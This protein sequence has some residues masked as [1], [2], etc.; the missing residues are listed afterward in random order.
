M[1]LKATLLHQND[2]ASYIVHTYTYVHVYTCYFAVYGNFVY[3]YDYPIFTMQGV[4]ITG[5]VPC[6]IVKPVHLKF[7][8]QSAFP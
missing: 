2:M 3:N 8:G 6:A 5:H 7:E 4:N 1:V